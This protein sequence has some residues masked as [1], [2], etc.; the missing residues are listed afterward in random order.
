MARDGDSHIAIDSSS[1][2][3][4]AIFGLHGAAS[5]LRALWLQRTWHEAVFRLWYLAAVVVLPIFVAGSAASLFVPVRAFRVVTPSL[6]ALSLTGAVL[7]LATALRE[8]IRVL[9][10]GPLH[11]KD[12]ATGLSSFRRT[13]RPSRSSQASPLARC[14]WEASA[15][16]RSAGPGRD[17]PSAEWSS[18]A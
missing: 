15:T 14:S 17:G 9:I 13:S 10:G 6:L 3:P 8:D 1:A 7:V 11:A 5:T 12:P 16:E 4:I 18:S 2:L